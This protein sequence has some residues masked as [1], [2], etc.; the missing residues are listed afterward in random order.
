MV[1]SNFFS[2]ELANTNIGPVAYS[3]EDAPLSYELVHLLEG[4]NEIPYD[5][6]I[7]KV[8]ENKKGLIIEDNLETLNEEIS[9]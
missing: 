1:K 7:K 4:K 8:S 5:F 2:L 9:K 3:P 6:K